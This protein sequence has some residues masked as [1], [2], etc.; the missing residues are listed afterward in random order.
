MHF[1]RHTRLMNGKRAA[2]PSRARSP[3]DVGSDHGELALGEG[4]RVV[5]RAAGDLEYR[6]AGRC[7]KQGEQTMSE[8][9]I[10]S[11]G[12]VVGVRDPVVLGCH[13][14]I[15]IGIAREAEQFA[16]A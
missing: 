5:A 3:G 8:L 9:R 7:G 1:T 6:S 15:L 12:V 14:A 11:P 2:A 4:W 13:F 16:V 10:W